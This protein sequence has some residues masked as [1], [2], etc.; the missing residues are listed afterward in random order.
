MRK[1][2][3]RFKNYRLCGATLVVTLEP[4]LMCMGAAIHAR[5]SRL[6]FG[7]FDPKGGAA[8]SLY[9]VAEDERLNHRIDVFP[10]ILD[11][12]CSDLIRR[13]FQSRRQK[14]KIARRGTEV[15]VTGSTRNRLV[16]LE[17]GHVGSNPT[18]S[19]TRYD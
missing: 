1:A 11:E 19:A 3:E 13:F 2:G 5:I 14:Q 4:C 17:A 18:L 10:G 8:G 7:A 15:V 12:Q 9:N 6:V 16:P